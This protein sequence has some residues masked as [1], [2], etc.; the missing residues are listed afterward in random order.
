MEEFSLSQYV[1]TKEAE[2]IQNHQ[3]CMACTCNNMVTAGK[4]VFEKKNSATVLLVEQ[5]FYWY[6]L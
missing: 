1:M 4:I 2:C 5:M 3:N 6:G